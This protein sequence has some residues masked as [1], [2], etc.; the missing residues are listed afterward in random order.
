MAEPGKPIYRPDRPTGV[1][2]AMT[3]M[4]LAGIVLVFVVIFV[5]SR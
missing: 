1:P 4:V 5:V 2:L 3:L